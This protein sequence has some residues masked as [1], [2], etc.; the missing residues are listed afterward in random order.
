MPRRLVCVAVGELAWQ[1]YDEPDLGLG[2]VR[3]RAEFAAAKHGTEMSFFKGY[4]TQRGRFDA[5]YQLFR[6]GDSGERRR[7]PAAVGNMMVGPVVD[8]G[9]EVDRL[10]VGDRVCLFSG[11]RETATVDQNACWVMPKGMSWRSAV[12]LDPAE[13]AFG[14]VRDG[15]VRIGDAV[16]VFGLGAIGLMAVQLARLSGADPV[17]GI[18][19]LPNRRAVAEEVGVTLTLDPR[20]CDVGLA[21][22]ELTDKRGVDVA[23][24]YSGAQ[25]AVQQALRGVAYGGTVVL[26]SYPAPY[27][28]G[29]DFGAEAHLNVPN[30]VFSRACS[31]PDRD[32]PR[33]T[34]RRIFDTCWRRLGDGT[35][36][37]EPIVQPVVA[38]DDLLTEYPRIAT[39]P[40]SNVKLGARL[41]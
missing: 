32:H 36:T 23:I 4:G 15:H 39:D 11:F 34:E 41:A 5:D 9:P 27:G 1:E 8:L 12:C 18:D 6:R 16:A 31:Q 7:G 20:E 19:P 2:Q 14:A 38:F 33:W 35:L 37:G 25:G 13:F 40:G 3:V 21:L 24:D 22:K 17:V 28:V 29:L 10:Q 30:V 26:G